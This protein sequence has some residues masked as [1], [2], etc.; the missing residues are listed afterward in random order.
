MDRRDIRH[1]RVVATDAACGI[2][3]REVM[4]VEPMQL[5]IRLGALLLESH[6][7]PLQNASYVVLDCGECFLADELPQRT[8]EDLVA[9]ASEPCG[10]SLIDKAVVKIAVEIGD[11]CRHGVQNALQR[12]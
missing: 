12:T 2:E 7:F 4:G 3:I 10:V 9:L 1:Q 6:L 5:A 11:Q 8:I